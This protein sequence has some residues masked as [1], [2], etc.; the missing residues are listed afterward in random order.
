MNVHAALSSDRYPLLLWWVML[1][2]C[3]ARFS[4]ERSA[5]MALSGFVFWMLVFGACWLVRGLLAR[6]NDPATSRQ[7][8][9]NTVAILGMLL[10]VFTLNGDG[11]V[12]ALL[13]FLFAIQAAIFIV[14]HKRLHLWL[15]I[16]AAFAGVMFAAAESRSGI[17]LACAVW[18]MFASLGVLVFDQRSDREQQVLLKPIAP[19]A[20]T[21]AALQYVAMVLALTLPIYLLV[22]KPGGL[23]LGGMQASSAHDYGNDEEPRHARARDVLAN[24]RPASPDTERSNRAERSAPGEPAPTEPLNPSGDETP[25]PARPENGF[26]GDS[27]ST[28]DVQRDS[29]AGN[30]IVLFVKSAHN[31]YLRGKLY[32]RFEANR[33]H[34][35]LQPFTEHALD[36]GQLQHEGAPVASSTIKQTIEVVVRLDNV[37]L[38][39]PGLQRLRFPGPTVRVYEDGVH[40]V[41]RALRA[42]TIYST[43]SSIDLV[44]GR[45]ILPDHAVGHEQRYLQLPEDAT[46]RVRNLARDIVG[47]EPNPLA[48]A[49]LL[50][51]HLRENYE[52]SYETILKQG[53]TPIDAFLFETKRGHCEFF[54]SAL[55]VM[56]RAVKIPARVAT[57]F[58]LGEPNPLTGYYEVRGLDGHAWVEAYL[59]GT[60]WLMLEP[61]PFYPLPQSTTEASRQVLSETDR[62]LER[63]ASTSVELDPESL[64]TAVIV[65]AKE[66]WT[67]S[68][69]LFKSMAAVPRA[70]GWTMLYILAGGFGL[71]LMGYLIALGVTD[72]RSNRGIRNTLARSERADTRSATVLLAEAVESAAAPRGYV[73]K[74]QWTLREYVGH[75]ART[76]HA[77]PAQFSDLF[78]ACRYS[79]TVDQSAPHV[80]VQVR[81]SVQT[82]VTRNA[83]PRTMRALEHCKRVLHIESAG[84][85]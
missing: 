22:P 28:S 32:D 11:L 13:S 56:L 31:V 43:D 81:E 21:S 60:G 29:G 50:E 54:A 78:D 79:D 66:M 63:L 64:K 44:H 74:P 27:F 57:G 25:P 38:H 33:W 9:G 26:Y 49:L 18:F 84:R 40:E 16:A 34:R 17:F 42:D 19:P 5:P 39:A 30:G 68:R 83:W 72:W 70:L 73:R 77:V 58:S 3:A 15:I 12:P 82:V 36:R 47:D 65:A 80:L 48:K 61:T 76:D 51:K 7:K 4:A 53:Y 55:A 24:Q 35:E 67:Q 46:E 37:L 52:Y 14:A 45:Y 8:A 20:R 1:S 71:V 2:G 75:L 59:P 6:R 69:H 10:F 41:P 23:L 62:Y 85:L